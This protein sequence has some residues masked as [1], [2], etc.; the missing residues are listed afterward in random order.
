MK[1]KRQ[2]CTDKVTIH[3]KDRTVKNLNVSFITDPEKKVKQ[4]GGKC[5]FKT[6]FIHFYKSGS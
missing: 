5:D 1:Q 2:F 6:F 3:S 4:V